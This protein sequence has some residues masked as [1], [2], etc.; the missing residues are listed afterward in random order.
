LF[1]L[2]IACSTC[3]GAMPIAA[4]FGTSSQIRIE[5]SSTPKFVTWPTPGT[6]CSACSTL[7]WA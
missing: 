4:S 7:I 1:W 2:L 5:Y 3:W 6:R